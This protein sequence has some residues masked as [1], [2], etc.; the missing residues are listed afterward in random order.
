M[1]EKSLAAFGA[2]VRSEWRGV[3][4]DLPEITDDNVDSAVDNL[5]FRIRARRQE[6]EAAG[7]FGRA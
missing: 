5:L 3:A 1:V 7:A 2:S 6:I 4:R